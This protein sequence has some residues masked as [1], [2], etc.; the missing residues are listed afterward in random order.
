[1]MP[2]W[3]RPWMIKGGA[4][5]LFL[6]VIFYAGCHTQRLQDKDKINKLKQQNKEY[7]TIIDAFQDN[8]DELERGIAAQN[9]AI[10]DLGKESERRMQQLN[11]AHAAAIRRFTQANEQIIS[12]A[13]EEA[14]ALRE[15]LAGLSVAEACHQSWVE[16]ANER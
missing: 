1:M 3:I 12:D 6:F 5:F 13:R 16:L 10:E 2:L 15:R 8:C 9:K 7:V 14:D 11:A 4:V